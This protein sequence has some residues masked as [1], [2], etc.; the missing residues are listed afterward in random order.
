MVAKKTAVQQP[1][2]GGTGAGPATEETA[3]G[4]TAGGAGPGGVPVAGPQPGEPG[5]VVAAAGEQVVAAG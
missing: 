5:R 1:A 4:G 3:P 2:T